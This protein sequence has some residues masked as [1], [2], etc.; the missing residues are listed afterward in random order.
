MDALDPKALRNFVTVARIGSIRGAAEYLGLA[1]SIVSRQMADLEQQ[2]GSSMFERTSRGVVLTDAGKLVLEHARRVLDDRD[3]L[4]E[5]LDHLKGIQQGRVRLIAGEGFVPDL[6][7]NGLRGFAAIYPGVRFSF[8]LAG[9]DEVVNRVANSEADI[10][11]VYDPVSETRIKSIAIS[12][13]PL[14]LIARAGHPLLERGQL[15][16]ADCLDVPAAHLSKGHGVR[17]LVSRVAAHAGVALAPVL[18]T[19]SIEALR[20]FVIAG[21]GVT[22]LPRFAV[23]AELATGSVGASELTDPTLGD[24]CAHLIVRARRRLPL[25]VERLAGHLAREMMAFRTG[26]IDSP[27]A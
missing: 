10:G 20:R 21:L 24:A 19:S 12:R 26:P 18:E 7:E 27:S 16:L 22:F 2:L 23:S 14:C 9:T 8:D 11:V 5:Q 6:V 13:Q 4:A 1:P 17:H 3:L 25:S 15:W